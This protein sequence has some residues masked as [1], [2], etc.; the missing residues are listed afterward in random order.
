MFRTITS[1]MS[2]PT[3]WA[4]QTDLPSRWR[5]LDQLDRML[6][7]TFYQHLKHDFYT[8][9]T[10]GSEDIVPLL[11]RRPSSE[12]NLPSMVSKWSA[13]KLWVGRHIPRISHKTA[14]V[15][16]TIDQ[17]IQTTK[18]YQVMM[19]ATILGSVG[20]VAITFKID[21]SQSE[22]QVGLKVWRAKYCTPTFDD[23]TNLQA[24]RIHYNVSGYELLARGKMAA[25]DGTDV[26]GD[27]EYWW[28]RDLLPDSEITY[29]PTPVADFNP[30]QGFHK[31]PPMVDVVV[32]HDLGFVPGVWIRNMV[33][34]VGVDGAGSW[35]KA[36]NISIE[37]D[38][39]LSQ[40]ARG[41][42]YNCA[43]ELVIVGD[44]AGGG[45]SVGVRSPANYIHLK[46]GVKQ[47]GSDSFEG[48][49][50]ELL[51]MTGNGVKAAY[52]LIDKLRNMALEQLGA[53]RKD[54]EKLK[55]VMSAAAMQFMDEDSHDLVMELRSSYGD[56][57]ALEL[58]RKIVRAVGI[59]GDPR[60]VKIDWP[61]LYQPTAEDLAHLIPSLAIAVTPI[62]E[63]L[64]PEEAARASSAGGGDGDSDSD[65]GS[66]EQTHNAKTVTNKSAT[67]ASKTV[68]TEV[69]KG[70]GTAGGRPSVTPTGGK[71]L[72]SLLT[73]D[74]GSRFLK[75][76][77]DIDLL[78]STMEHGVTDSDKPTDTVDDPGKRVLG[79]E[80][81]STVSSDP[82]PMDQ[83]MTE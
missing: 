5:R 1:S 21:S 58:M 10:P 72:G 38:Y 71:S 47:E 63:P 13:R 60:G 6:D 66:G 54:P 31:Y 65:S 30:V 16:T 4:G 53:T 68:K 82:N 76:F 14:E 45:D 18:F 78:P 19:E 57:G 33:G 9:T 28:V 79:V 27:Q 50:A 41:T 61:R 40:A 29:V 48:G 26:Q 80:E 20:S 49:R 46:A 8:E 67:G 32:S 81:D 23:F 22:P 69:K 56:G 44:M 73:M 74:E 15:S 59:T 7:G 24:L 39:L 52:E 35:D 55:G 17:I 62:Q 75:Q 11:Q 2:Y 51:E 64:T 43:P 83:G 25:A 37:I 42:R 77:M 36:K 70:P 34:G 3:L 12:Y